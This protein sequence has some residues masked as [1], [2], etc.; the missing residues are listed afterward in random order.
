MKRVL[1]LIASPRNLGNCEIMVK[2]ISRNIPEPHELRLLKL[3]AFDLQSCRGCYT[4]LFKEKGCILKDDF[5]QIADEILAAD[6][7]ILAAPTYF[8]GPASSV[9]RLVDRFLALYSHA[10][11]LW[12]RPAVA[13]AI[14]G[15][16]GREGYTQLGLENFLKLMF[17]DIKDS[18]VVYGALPGEIF[19]DTNNKKIAYRLATALFGKRQVQNGP[20]CQVCGGKT[21]RFFKANEVRC[22]LCSNLGIF[23]TDNGQLRFD[24]K[25]GKHELFTSLEAAIE[26]RKWLKS[27]KIRFISEKTKLKNITQ[28]YLNEG[29]KLKPQ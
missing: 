17:A 5:G 10:E 23:T 25:T 1:A 8:L 14:A 6:A 26:H 24:I 16:K 13:I 9:K 28:G 18:Q 7:Y 15:I 2:E 21:F 12:G 22:M 3:P 19:Y 4:C 27:M 11:K 29:V 20:A